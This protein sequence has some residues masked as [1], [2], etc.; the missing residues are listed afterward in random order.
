MD[1]IQSASDLFGNYRILHN[2]SSGKTERGEWLKYFAKKTGRTIGFIAF[3]LTGVPT[4]DLWA[5]DKKCQEY[6]GGY[7]KCFWG[8]L[9]IK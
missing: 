3:K 5:F 7:E 8:C 6:K 4:E 1:E 2:P 9:K